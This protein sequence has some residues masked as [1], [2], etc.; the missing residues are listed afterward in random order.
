MANK[1]KILIAAPYSF[2]ERMANY[3]EFITAR[4]LAKNNWRVIGLV[5]RDDETKSIDSLYG[6][7]IYRYKNLAQGIFFLL[8]ILLIDRPTVVHIHNQRNNRLGILTAIMAKLTGKTLIFTEYGLLHDH[9]LVTDRDNPLGK[10]LK[11]NGLI[12]NLR[13]IFSYSFIKKTA[14]PP[15]NIKNYLFHWALTHADKIVFVSKHN[16]PIAKELGLKNYIYLPYIFDDARWEIKRAGKELSQ[17]NQRALKKIEKNGDSPLG[18]FIGQLKLRK[19][20]D[21][22][23]K[24]IALVDKAIIPYF[25]LITSSAS[26][27]PDFFSQMV[28]NLGIED[29]LI[30][31]GQV[32]NQT[33]KK[34]YDLS[35]III[36]PSRYEGFGLAAIE[37][38]ESKKPLIA[39]AVEALTETVIDNYN[40]LLVPPEN[41][42]KLASAICRLAQDR[43]LVKKLIAGGQITLKRLKSDELKNQW[44]DFYEKLLIAD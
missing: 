23:L 30:F 35:S 13:Q 10:P 24:T 7:K 25:V 1:K 31:F 33:L 20:W 29:R 26:R 19:G 18:F 15:A 43:A 9:Y 4:L 39:S 3:I 2:N 22:Y 34:I 32:D 8:N 27:P 14:S 42:Q 16:L 17:N 44:L 6:I 38:F 5:S 36:A 21:I 11:P 40:G 28:K 37:A 12:F 41:P